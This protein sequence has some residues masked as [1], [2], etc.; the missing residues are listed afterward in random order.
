MLVAA[1]QKALTGSVYSTKGELFF[2]K[3]INC[4]LIRNLLRIDRAD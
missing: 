2:K 4:A 1:Y 3:S